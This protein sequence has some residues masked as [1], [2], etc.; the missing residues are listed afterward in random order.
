MNIN[1]GHSCDR[2]KFVKATKKK[3]YNSH[4]QYMKYNILNIDILSQK[5]SSS[6]PLTILVKVLQN[7]SKANL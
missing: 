6:C 2:S 7:Y 1:A 5:E 3:L 4:L